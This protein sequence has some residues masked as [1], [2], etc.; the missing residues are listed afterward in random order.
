MA[1]I[2]LT[3]DDYG[4][5]ANAAAASDGRFRYAPPGNVSHIAGIQRRIQEVRDRMVKAEPALLIVHPGR[6]PNYPDCPS[7][8]HLAQVWRG[9][10]GERA[11]SGVGF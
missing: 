3:A 2:P 11:S 8:K 1:L 7:S 6:D 10:N 4:L 5:L 9:V